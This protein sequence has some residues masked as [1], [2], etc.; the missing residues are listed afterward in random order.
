MRHY[1]YP[2]CL[3]VSAFKLQCFISLF[4]CLAAFTKTLRNTMSVLQELTCY[5]DVASR[6]HRWLGVTKQAN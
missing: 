6:V 1:L 3:S 5:S 4:A 2:T